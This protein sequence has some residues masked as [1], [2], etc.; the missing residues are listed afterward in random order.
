MTR[1]RD[2]TPPGA[3][4]FRTAVRVQ[5]GD[6]DI[7]GICYFAAYWR[8][9]ERA[10][11][12]MFGELGFPYGEIFD[13]Y[14]MWLPR[15]DVRAEYHAPALMDDRLDLRTHLEK[16]GGSSVRWK[17]VVVNERTGE[18]GAAFTLTVAC[19]DRAS[20]KSVALPAEMRAA[21][22]ACTGDAWTRG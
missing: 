17:T 10:E 7:A 15:V 8:F 22:L 20:K 21:L 5:W 6:V 19:M 3:R 13:R 2:T 9:V 4:V 14:D 1:F 12:D 16:V 11:M 18:A